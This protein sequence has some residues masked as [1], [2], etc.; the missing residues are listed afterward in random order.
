MNG[1]VQGIG[2]YPGLASLGLS[3]EAWNALAEK[4]NLCAETG[5]CGTVYKIRFRMSGRQQS[6]YVGKRPGFVEQIRHELAQLQGAARSQ[7]RLQRLERQAKR[8]IRKTI[9]Q[10]ETL[11][12][13]AGRA[14]HGRS[15]RRQRHGRMS[16]DVVE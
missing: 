13:G 16:V 15:I 11:L 7:E 2:S 14:F 10:I 1:L 3:P 5:K 6:R 9:R 8:C 12:P 4:G